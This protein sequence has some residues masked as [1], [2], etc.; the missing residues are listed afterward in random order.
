MILDD[1]V[2]NLV[3]LHLVNKFEKGPKKK[4]HTPMYRN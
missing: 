3:L 1:D 4:R 2:D